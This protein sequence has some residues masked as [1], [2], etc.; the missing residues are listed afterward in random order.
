[1]SA[2]A[3]SVSKLRG[4]RHRLIWSVA[5][6]LG[7]AAVLRAD[8]LLGTSTFSYTGSNQSY[9]TPAGTNYVVIKVWGGGGGSGIYG[10]GGS[11]GFAKGTY[12]LSGGQSLTVVVGGGGSGFSGSSGAWPNGGG[13]GT[14]GG[15]QGAGAGSSRVY[16]SSFAVWAGGGGGGAWGY[17][18]GGGGGPTGG[19]G[20]GGSAGY[21]GTQSAGG[22][23]GDSNLEVYGE[24]GGY[25]Q[26]GRGA[27]D[28]AN[29]GGAGGGGGYYG[30]G[31]AGLGYGGGGG[32]GSSIATGSPTSYS[33]AGGNGSG[34]GGTGD[35][36][37]PGS[38]AGYGTYG[39]YANGNGGY[40]VIQA[41]QT[42]TAPT[43]TSSGAQNVGQNQAID[44]AITTTGSPSP[45]SYG[46]TSL[47]PGLSVNTST[48]HITGNPTTAGTYNS[49]I[50]ATNSVGTGSA[51]VTWTVTAASITPAATVSP[52]IVQLGQSVSLTRAGTANFGVAWTE[53]IM[54]RPDSSA[55]NLGNTSLGGP[56]SYT[57]ATGA[58]NYIYQF[59]LVDNYYNYADQF[60]SYEVA[61]PH[62]LPYSAGF[63]SSESFSTGTLQGQQGWGVAQGTATVSTEQAQTGSRGV[64]LAGGTPLAQVRSYFTQSQNWVFAD[65]YVRPVAATAVLDSTLLDYGSSKIG[66]V[67][68]SGQ[69]AIYAYDGNGTGGGSWV[70][71]GCRFAINGSNQ[72]TSWLRLTVRHDYSAHKW[73]LF[74]NGVIGDYDLGMVLNTATSLT[75]LTWWGHAS[76]AAYFDDFT[77]STT[78]PL[79]TDADHDGMADAWETANGLST[80]TDD[81]NSDHD[82]DGRSN[83]R[84]YFEGTRA[85]NA[86]V[87]APSTT[88]GLTVTGTTPSTVSLA[89]NTSTDTGAGTSGMAGYHVY[90]NG[91]RVTSTP[92]SGLTYTD[93]GLA[94]STS[95]TYS[96][97]AVDLA[98]NL[99]S[100]SSNVTVTT[101]AASSSGSFEVL[102]PLP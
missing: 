65:V 79:F 53:N 95:Y 5:L 69:G 14:S 76:A 101:P 75:D 48:G 33:Y 42:S 68:V 21:G 43:I 71:T 37:Y 25:N 90:R 92:V 8:T 72:A 94:A 46:A 16:N 89:W 6:A 96:V 82:S 13:V 50:S 26:G 47:P 99:S 84:E 70:D 80:S 10:Q 73:D 45:S 67:I 12:T 55:Q 38:P 93:T 39:V 40:V 78:N 29:L 49:T 51:S 102:T 61:S 44:Y 87:T 1:M 20:G 24:D 31:G 32:G 2:P 36:S 100:F 34:P 60:I 22:W 83:I 3:M 85:D 35:P 63:E 98:G 4:I 77:A 59:R 17:V 9:T 74:V 58:G 15:A 18:G 64:K 30:G 56:T 88:T 86:D 66:F 41:Y 7:F 23:G 91:V 28:G 19:S 62:S 27:D 97:R 57:P 81:R 11:G 52:L 54:W